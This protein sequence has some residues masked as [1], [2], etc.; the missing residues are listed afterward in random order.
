MGDTITALSV[1]VIN[2]TNFPH[3]LMFRPQPTSCK[4]KM[5]LK[6]VDEFYRN[7]LLFIGM[8]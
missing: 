8:L 7:V 2:S 3:S 5:I 6:G 1:K 4:K